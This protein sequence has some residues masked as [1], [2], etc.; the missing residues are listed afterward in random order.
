MSIT[1]TISWLVAFLLATWLL[2]MRTTLADF[3][4]LFWI[5]IAAET[6]TRWAENTNFIFR[7]SRP[8]RPLS[9]VSDGE[10]RLQKAVALLSLSLLGAL[11]LDVYL[12]KTGV[13]D[14]EVVFIGQNNVNGHD[15]MNSMVLGWVEALN[16]NQTVAW[17]LLGTLLRARIYLRS[18]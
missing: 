14:Q 9:Q 3:I 5:A 8:N 4:V 17:L 13:S 1:W 15:A 16:S 6:T 2:E 11:F 12:T 18:T 7:A 10:F